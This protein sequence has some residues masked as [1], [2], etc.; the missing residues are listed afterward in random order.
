LE[1]KIKNNDAKI[2]KLTKLIE[3]RTAQKEKTIEEIAEVDAHMKE[4]TAVR[5]DENDAFLTAKKDDQD[6]IDLLI[7]ARDALT[8]YYKKHGI[9]MG[10]VQGSVKGLA[11]AQD[12]PEFDVSADQAPDAV[13][14]H[15]GK[16]K[17]ESKDIVSILTMIIEDLNDEIK[18]GMKAEEAA[19]LEYEAQMKAAEKL[20]AELDAKRISL[21]A[22]IAKR[23]GERSDERELKKENEDE[24]ED[25]Q[26]YKASIKPDCDWIIGAFEKRAA[27]RAA[28]MNGL[29]GAKEFLAGYQPPAEASLLEA[30]KPFDDRALARTHFLGIRQ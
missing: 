15:K 19:Q 30:A 7:A 17:N 23:E 9:D 29:V 13:F 4:I 28:E 11:L 24:L 5:K 1:W 21:I 26:N 18:N 16:R 8:A 12:E 22:A 27:A 25:E 6:A 20:R 2:D 14:S 3:L 10:P